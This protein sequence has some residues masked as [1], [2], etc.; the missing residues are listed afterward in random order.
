MVWRGR[1]TETKVELGLVAA[2][3]PLLLVCLLQLGDIKFFHFEKCLGYAW[4]RFS[5]L[6]FSISSITVGTICHDKPYLS[7]SQPHCSDRGS[8]ESFSQ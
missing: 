4:I 8:A 3:L 1:S 2:S 6:P 7:F 5:S